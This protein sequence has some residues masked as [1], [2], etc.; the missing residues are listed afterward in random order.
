MNN[1]L[2][3]YK[4]LSEP[5]HLYIYKYIYII[6]GDKSKQ[7]RKERAFFRTYDKPILEFFTY[8]RIYIYI[9]INLLLDSYIKLQGS[10]EVLVVLKLPDNSIGEV[11][12]EMKNT[13]GWVVVVAMTVE[14]NVWF[15]F[16]VK[17]AYQP[18]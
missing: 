18:L 11:S 17:M 9:Y 2:K 3:N 5:L 8:H 10:L 14:E 13:L 6:F 12:I 16:F 15:S 4:S 1:T 7:W